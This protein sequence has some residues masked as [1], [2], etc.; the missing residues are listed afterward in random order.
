M[1][2]VILVLFVN[3]VNGFC[4]WL[5]LFLEEYLCAIKLLKQNLQKKRLKPTI[6]LI[7]IWKE[8]FQE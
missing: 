4:F 2:V 5:I 7:L 6:I 8:L 1:D 3:N